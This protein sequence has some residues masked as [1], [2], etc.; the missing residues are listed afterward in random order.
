[1]YGVIDIGSNT[2]RLSIYKIETGNVI[3]QLTN[4]K[5]VVGLAR[6]VD[7]NKNMSAK[8]I[9]KTISVLKEYKDIIKCNRTEKVFIFATASIRNINNTEEVVE[10]IYN[11]TK[12][13]V[14]V[15]SGEEEAY[16]DYIGATYKN[17]IKNGIIMDIGGGSTELVFIKDKEIKKKI[18]LP[19]GSLNTYTN[20]VHNLIPTHKEYKTIKKIVINYLDDIEL[21]N[22]EYP[23]IYGIGGAIRG[24]FKINNDIS[25]ELPE[26]TKLKA[27]N[28]KSLVKDFI[29]N[30]KN[31]IAEI[32]E[33]VPDRI[34]TIMPGMIILK[35][36]SKYYKCENIVLSPYGI[37]EGFLIENIINKTNKGC[38]KT[39]NYCD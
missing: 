27:K 25:N 16:Y 33:I 24:T 13:I 18:S 34:H 31:A 22:K 20:Y 1:M 7:N 23:I 2:I 21:D 4:K 36:M 6:Y 8:G 30:P 14:E 28:V 5:K 19:I 10:R 38:K 9:K 29:E 17:N 15:I 3:K 12:M 11:E 39:Y 32:I 37:R 35:V 26:N